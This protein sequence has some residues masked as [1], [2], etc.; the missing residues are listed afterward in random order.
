MSVM[1]MRTYDIKE[2]DNIDFEIV[3]KGDI[4]QIN[5]VKDLAD[6]TKQIKILLKKMTEHKMKI[7]FIPFK[8]DVEP[9]F[10]LSLFNIYEELRNKEL[11]ERQYT[12]IKRALEMKKEGTGTYGRPKVK[13]PDD[14]EEQVMDC[15][16][17][18]FP[19]SNYWKK[20]DLPQS[21]FYKYA[22]EIV[23]R[24][25]YKQDDNKTTS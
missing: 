18:S 15:V 16:C 19:L 20:I 13:L 5:S 14:F 11:R 25:T 3:S 21:T 4:L 2:F 1:D 23:K 22:N 10:I 8:C 24:Q 9:T 7:R 12:G 6:D 17:Q